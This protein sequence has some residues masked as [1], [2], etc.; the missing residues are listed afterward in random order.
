[1]RVSWEVATNPET[2]NMSPPVVKEKTTKVATAVL[3]P[4]A[5]SAVMV[6]PARIGPVQPIPAAL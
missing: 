1:M 5:D 2:N 3:K 4:P 6:S